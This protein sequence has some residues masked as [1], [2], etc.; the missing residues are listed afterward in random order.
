ML[1]GRYIRRTAETTSDAS[2]LWNDINDRMKRHCGQNLEPDS[3]IGP[4]G[5]MR[6]LTDICSQKES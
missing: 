6:L 2:G 1:V 4:R 3:L 5:K